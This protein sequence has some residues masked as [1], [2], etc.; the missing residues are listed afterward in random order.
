M[1]KPLDC[2]ASCGALLDAPDA[3]CHACNP[4]LGGA[5]PGTAEGK[6]LCPS[7][8]TRFGAVHRRAWPPG[9]P[10]YQFQKILPQCPNCQAFLQ[11][12][13]A[14][15]LLSGWEGLAIFV[16][17]QFI[18]AFSKA[19][20]KWVVLSALVAFLIWRL[21]RDT[22]RQSAIAEQH[23]YLPLQRS[24]AQRGPNPSLP[25]TH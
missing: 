18:A 23:R 12:C 13:R 21:W 10:W 1:H 9:A 6:Y 8:N 25:D 5:L 4:P 16:V 15:P 14:V 20:L 22:H 11:D 24:A 2:C 17:Y 7:C 19:G 3:I